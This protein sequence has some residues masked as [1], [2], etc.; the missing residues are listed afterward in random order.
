MQLMSLI[1]NGRVPLLILKDSFQIN[2]SFALW[3]CPMARSSSMAAAVQAFRA[4]Y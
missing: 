1:I 3:L 4:E 2:H